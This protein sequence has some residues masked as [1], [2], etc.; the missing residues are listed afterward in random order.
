MTTID[1]NP[2]LADEQPTDSWWSRPFQMFQTNL[3]EIDAGLDVEKALDFIQAHGANT[4]LIN[5]GGILAFHPSDLPFQTRNPHLSDRVGGDLLGDAVRS[6]HARGV[7]VM[8]R[9]DFSKVYP[10]LADN[11]PEWCFVSPTGERQ[12]YEGLVSVCP[13][14]PYYQERTF[15]V[16]D[17]VLDR[18]PVD[19]FFFNWFGFNEV[20]Y[21]RVYH[22]VCHCDGCRRGFSR[23]T[24]LD[25]L[26]DGPE[27][28][29]YEE[30]KVFAARTVEDLTARLRAHITERRPDA[31]LILGKKSDIIFHEAN[32]A[33]GRELWHHA[34]AE[35]VSASKS[36]HPDKPVLVNS[37]AFIDMP[38]R[39]AAEEPY[40]FASY[41]AQAIAR[42]ANPST[43]IMGPPGAVAYDNLPAAAEITRFHARW[44]S[45]Y[46]G[47]TPSARIALVRPDRLSQPSDVHE[48]SVAEFR[49]FYSALQE[50]HMPFDVVPVEAIA[51]LAE[52]GGLTRYDVVILPDVGPLSSATITALDRY[53]ERGSTIVASGSS[54]IEDGNVQL[55]SMPAVSVRAVHDGVQTNRSSYFVGD[56]S[57]IPVFG[58]RRDFVWKES[59]AGRMRLLPPA[60]FGPP[61]KAYGH[62]PTNEPSYA[63]ASA[64]DGLGVQFA[65]TIGRA[66]REL[67][68]TNLRRA[69]IESLVSAIGVDHITSSELPEQVEVVVAR[70][71]DAQVVHL[72]NFSGARRKSFG[73]P[74]PV[75]GGRLR[76]PA[77]SG[78]HVRALV[79]DVECQSHR[80]GEDLII[81]LPPIGVFEVIVVSEHGEEKE[82]IDD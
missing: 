51:D 45:V 72:L 57:V 8:A 71:Q 15:D 74:M 7:R 50:T 21:G 73:P 22:G 38:Y 11:H 62:V 5:A 58:T 19:G 44:G 37:V 53:A 52:N 69:I 18:Y 13:S 41:F 75:I 20:D 29:G 9:M 26:P 16:L 81:D 39:M 12:V 65:W 82:P 14:A 42:G 23:A 55:T 66:Y 47:L 70:N 76:L 4:W 27:S 2:V 24:G 30:W 46:D 36:V 60:P 64:G 61:E 48:R 25:D 67:G 40:H 17:E 56:E 10:A 59:A 35:A 80:D 68:T 49:G 63:V 3:R 31:A 1:P 32:N 43:Y 33:V 77:E 79:A 28:P 6:A 54:A 78:A 34:T